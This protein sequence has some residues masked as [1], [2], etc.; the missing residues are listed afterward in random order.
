MTNK[1]IHQSTQAVWGGEKDYLAHGASQVPVV[2]SVAYTYDD[3][4]DWYDVA[5]GKKKGHIYG[6]NTNPTVQAFEDKVKLLEG[7]EAATSFSTGMAAISNTLATFLVPG[8]RIVSIKDTYG[9]TNKIFTEFL[10]RQQIDVALVD[11]G[12]HEAIEAELKKGCKILYLETP[13]NP[14]VKI[15]DIARM[16]KAGHEVGAL[17][18]IDNTFGTPI[19]QNPLE[20]GVD[21][22]LH[23]ATKFLGGHAD[24]LGGVL[25]GSHELVEQV[26][27]YREINGATMDPMAAY[28]LLRGMKTLH[29]RI[30]EQSKNA[31]ALAKYLQTKDIVEDVFYPGLETHPNHD[32]AKRQMKGFG[33]MLSFSVKGGVDTVRDLLPKLQYANRAA[34]LGAVETTVGPARTTSHV[35]CTPEERAA[36]GIPEGLIRVSCGI[37]EIE[38]IINDFEQAFQHVE[39]VMN[40]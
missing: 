25:V 6:R 23:S 20:D 14:T 31:M 11:T 27:H 39:T 19:N 38:D 16:A 17:V 24:A 22:V 3:M 15:T 18:I 29:L 13:T 26:Y 7:A 35:E 40:V 30:R 37:E 1:K 5:I 8:D 12:D 4:D 36:M 34:N 32:I 33:G 28:L 10:P 9:G 2:L 21:L